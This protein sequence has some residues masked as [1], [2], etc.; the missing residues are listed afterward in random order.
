MPATERVSVI[1]LFTLSYCP[2]NYLNIFRIPCRPNLALFGPSRERPDAT[3]L[4]EQKQASVPCTPDMASVPHENDGIDA[5]IDQ[6]LEA[7]AARAAVAG[8]AT[9]LTVCCQH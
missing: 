3:S 2:Y 8:P 4:L 6:V 1:K 9:C 7:A 5:A